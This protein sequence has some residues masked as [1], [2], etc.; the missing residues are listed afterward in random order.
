VNAFHVCGAILAAWAVIV[1][2][3]GITRENFPTS[4][5]S[6]RLIGSI[7]VLL[8]AA[9]IGTAIYTSATEEHESGEGEHDEAAAL[10]A[11]DWR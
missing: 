8:V 4:D 10:V 5:G 7:S 11:P 2:I 1:S 9:A 3:L 6:A